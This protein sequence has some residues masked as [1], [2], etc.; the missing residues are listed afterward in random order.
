MIVT[1]NLFGDILSDQA[2]MCAGSIGMLPSA[3]LSSWRSSLGLYEPIHGSAP[4]IAGQGKA[5]PC[6]DDPVGGDDAATIRSTGERGAADRGGGGEGDR[7]RRADGRSRRDALD[8][9]DGRRDARRPM[10]DTLDL[11]VVIPTFNE[12]GNVPLLVAKLDAALAGRRLGSDLRRRQ[13][14]RRHRRRGAR[15]RRGA[16]AACG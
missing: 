11:A 1:G 16:T 14:P 15:A 2:S 10:T 8:K 13:Q 3:S 6:A 9:R 4:D 12:R 7:R 5:N